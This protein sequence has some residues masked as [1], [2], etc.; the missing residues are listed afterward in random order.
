MTTSNLATIL[1]ATLPSATSTTLGGVLVDS[2]SSGLL[3]MTDGHIAV[4]YTTGL[5]IDS[6]GHLYVDSTQFLTVSAAFTEYAQ[7]SSLSNYLLLTGG[8]VQNH[9]SVFDSS[10]SGHNIEFNSG[11]GGSFLSFNSPEP[12]V[13]PGGIIFSDNTTQTT[14]FVPT[15]IYN[16]NGIT[17]NLSTIVSVIPTSGSTVFIAGN[18]QIVDC[19]TITYTGTMPLS[20]LTPTVDGQYIEVAI[21]DGPGA[22]SASGLALDGVTPVTVFLNLGTGAYTNG[23]F[24]YVDSTKTWYQVS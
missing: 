9:L 20:F 10:A 2:T 6:T 14:A 15:A 5:Q 13:V 8:D 11:S 18:C 16:L 24:R 21:I 7:I 19:S 23:A 1:T 22:Y 12:S 17:S 4:K 3:A